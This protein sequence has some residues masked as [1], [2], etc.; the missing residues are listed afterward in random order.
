MAVGCQVLARHKRS[1]LFYAATVTD[2]RMQTFYEVDFDEGTVSTDLFPEDVKV[3][4]LKHW[5]VDK[6]TKKL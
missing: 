1:C 6:L 2:I 4:I 3:G 5:H